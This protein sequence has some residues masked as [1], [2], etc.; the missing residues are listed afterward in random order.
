MFVFV[1][2]FDLCMK[3]KW[4]NFEPFNIWNS[5]VRFICWYRLENVKYLFLFFWFRSD[6]EMAGMTF[7]K[8]QFHFVLR[9]QPKCVQVFIGHFF[10]FFSVFFTFHRSLFLRRNWLFNVCLFVFLLVL[11]S[12]SKILIHLVAVNVDFISFHFGCVG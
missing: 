2:D 9:S 7:N 1:C 11:L 10:L 3:L 4:N 5:T 8:W 12:L 6:H